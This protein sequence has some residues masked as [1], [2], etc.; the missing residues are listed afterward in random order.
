MKTDLIDVKIIKNKDDTYDFIKTFEQK[1]TLRWNEMLNE[2]AGVLATIKDIENK[3]EED[4]IEEFK[5]SLPQ[6]K[7]IMKNA[8]SDLKRIEKLMK[9]ITKEIKK[10]LEKKSKGKGKLIGKDGK[11]KAEY[12]G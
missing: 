8:L 2:Y 9:P 3:K 11:A 4:L 7:E 1:N 5:K 12:F 6:H 10:D